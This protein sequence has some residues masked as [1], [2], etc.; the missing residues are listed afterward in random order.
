MLLKCD[1]LFW[2]ASQSWTHGI[3]TKTLSVKLGVPPWQGPGL[4]LGLQPLAPCLSEYRDTELRLIEG[5]KELL[6][7]I[8]Q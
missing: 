7:L 6:L 5:I 4:I 1:H 3:S 2:H 8:H